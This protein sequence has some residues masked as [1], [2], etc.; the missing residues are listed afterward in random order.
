MHLLAPRRP[1]KFR[2]PGTITSGVLAAVL[3]L[4]FTLTACGGE[5]VSTSPGGAPTSTAEPGEL[6]VPLNIVTSS[7][8]AVLALAPVYINNQ[9]PFQFALDTGASNSLI[10]SSLVQQLGLPVVGRAGQVTGVTGAENAEAVM[11]NQ[12]RVGD[13]PLPATTA[14][15]LALPQANQGPGL[16][17]LLGSDILSTFDAVM[18]DYKRQQ[19][20]LNEVD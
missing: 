12:W 19:L 15:S 6:I 17:G 1:R 9:G 13:V 20:V 2:N 7:G 18:V 5:A 8:G 16:V 11:V 4:S 10:D 14:I 3:V